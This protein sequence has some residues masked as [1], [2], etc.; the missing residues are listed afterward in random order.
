MGRRAN[1]KEPSEAELAEDRRPGAVLAAYR[2]LA[3]AVPGQDRARDQ[4]PGLGLLGAAAQGRAVRRQLLREQAERGPRAGAGVEE[5]G[6]DV[7]AAGY[8]GPRL[9]EGLADRIG[10]LAGGTGRRHEG[11]PLAGEQVAEQHRPRHL[12][13][14]L[15]T[16][17]LLP[18]GLVL[19]LQIVVF[20]AQ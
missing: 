18:L 20:V 1:A 17:D 4:L 14:L 15:I 10:H 5:L 7:D 19:G 16:L 8:L 9:G 2:G 11:D 3:E 12:R 6:L 13:G